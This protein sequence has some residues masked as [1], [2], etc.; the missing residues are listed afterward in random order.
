MGAIMTETTSGSS[1]KV[2]VAAVID[3]RRHAATQYRII[4]SGE[5]ILQRTGEQI[6]R[7]CQLHISAAAWYQNFDLMAKHVAQWCADRADKIVA[8]LVAV[9]TDKTIFYIIHRND[10]YDFD[11]GSQQ[12]DLD[13]FLNTRGGI[14][15]AE[16]RQV[17]GWEMDRFVSADAYRVWP[18]DQK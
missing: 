3:E 15:Y 18:P 6:V 5:E 10:E 9:R 2:P 14:G 1:K 8:G 7:A 13:I 17:P 12:A 11:L 4:T 16:T